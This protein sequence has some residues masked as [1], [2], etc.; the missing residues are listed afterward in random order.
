MS[1][2]HSGNFNPEGL[3]DFVE[4]SGIALDTEVEAVDPSF[5]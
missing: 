5:L 3:A 1:T 4:L 2:V